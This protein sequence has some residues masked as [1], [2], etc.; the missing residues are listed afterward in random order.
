[1]KVTIAAAIVVVIVVVLLTCYHR[2]GN[3]RSAY[4]YIYML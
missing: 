2:G 4:N 1:M 3:V